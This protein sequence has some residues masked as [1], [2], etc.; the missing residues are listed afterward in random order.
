MSIDN[1]TDEPRSLTRQEFCHLERMSLSTY[2]KL[3]R[4]G[5]GPE[6]VKFPGMAFVRITSEARRDWHK[7]INELRQTEAS[8]LEEARR[9]ENA[10]I[11]GKK[12]AASPLHVSKRGKTNAAATKRPV[13]I[14]RRSAKG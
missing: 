6:E 12:A 3:Q 14:P 8:K 13:R 9:R 1:E 10:S 11:A 2:H 4:T 7:T 5:H